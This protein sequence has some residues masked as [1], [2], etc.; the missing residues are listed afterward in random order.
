[1]RQVRAGRDLDAAGASQV[2]RTTKH[3]DASIEDVTLVYMTGAPADAP[4][5]DATG[6]YRLEV[7][8]RPPELMQVTFIMLHGGSDELIVRAKTRASI[9]RFIKLNDLRRHPRLRRMTITGPGGLREEIK[10]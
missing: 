4:D 7:N 6:T 9:D 2:T 5:T 10:R 3:D 8:L 1:V